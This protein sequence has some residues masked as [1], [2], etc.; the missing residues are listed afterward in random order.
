MKNRVFGFLFIAVYFFTGGARADV[1]DMPVV[2]PII[3]QLYPSNNELSLSLA[4]VP[5]GAF[6]KYVG[7]G[8]SYLRLENP[9][10][11]WEVLSG[12]YFS[13]IPSGLKQSVIDGFGAQEADFPVLKYLVKTGYTYVPFYSKSI[14]FNSYLLHSRSYL[15]AAVGASDFVIEKPLFVSG[16]FGQNFYFGKGYAFKFE[17]NYFN[18]FKKNKYIQNQLT[19]SFGLVFGWS[20]DEEETDE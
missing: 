2:S 10:H 17:V 16:G 3:N 8:G 20:P 11:G 13:E 18:F 1:Y 15:N 7:F 19:V 12:Y 14:L 4:Y 5:I 9:N 6:N